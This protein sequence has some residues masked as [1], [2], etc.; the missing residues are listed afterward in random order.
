MN[1]QEDIEDKVY[2]ANFRVKNGYDPGP[3][4]YGEL[5]LGYGLILFL[6]IIFFLYN[7]LFR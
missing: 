4:G 2:R 1:N 6:I 7:G 5:D 3:G